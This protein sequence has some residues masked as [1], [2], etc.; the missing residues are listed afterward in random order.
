MIFQS[1]DFHNV[2]EIVPY[3]DGFRLWRV[4]QS[5]RALAN[6]RLNETTAAYSTGIELRFRMVSD[7]VTI[8]LRSVPIAEGQMAYL[9]F[10]SL[11]GGWQQSSWIIRD[12]PTAI[13]IAK[14]GNLAQMQQISA[15]A[16]LPFSPEVVRLVL[17]YGN[18]LFLGLEGEVAPPEDGM[19]PKTTLMCYGSSITHG[20][21]ALA[22][23]YT[24]PFRIAQKL[25]TDYLN[26]GFAGTAH[27]DRAIAE[28]LVSRRDWH[29]AT[30]EMGINMLGM[31]EAE[32][33]ERVDTFTGIFADD[34]RPVFATS[35]FRFNGDHAGE[36]P[37]KA[38]VFRGIVRK[39]ASRRMH[40][41]D[42]LE[43]LERPEFISQDM[44]HPSLEGIAQIADRWTDFIRP[45]L[46]ESLL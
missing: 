25:G 45:R 35:I 34:G 24:Y 1:I 28:W 22:S 27:C 15:Q 12:E 7:R 13:T 4:P 11:Q 18:I 43:L 16:R 37:S 3:E 9:Y 32:F 19:L 40:F 30:L 33:E 46:P 14:P 38:D 42:G 44:V 5:V 31:T 26:C 39:Y 21:L 6:P 10:G 41:I 8:R 20:S 2:A 23:P 29:F 36:G 17:P